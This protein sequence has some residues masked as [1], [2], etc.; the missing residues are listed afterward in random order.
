MEQQSVAFPLL[1]GIAWFVVLPIVAAKNHWPGWTYFLFLAG[2]WIGFGIWHD[3]HFG[4][5]RRKRK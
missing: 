5:S 1:S 2:W 3:K 4:M